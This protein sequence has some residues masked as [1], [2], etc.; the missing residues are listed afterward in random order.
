MQVYVV[1]VLVLAQDET[2][3]GD[4][5]SPSS[6]LSPSSRGHSPKNLFFDYAQ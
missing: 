4:S 1:F 5:N 3:H 6:S 2:D